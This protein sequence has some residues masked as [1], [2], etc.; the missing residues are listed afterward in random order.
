[1]TTPPPTDLLWVASRITKPQNLTPSAFCDWYENT[2]IQEVTALSGIP[3]AARYELLPGFDFPGALQHPWLT[4][5]EMREVGFRETEEF[6]GLD[7]Q[8]RPDEGLL[9]RVFGNV[10]FDTRFWRCVQVD[11]AAGARK[12]PAPLIISA[13][14]SPSP[15]AEA[16]FDAWYRQEHVPMISQC[17]GYV[18]TRRYRL[19]DASLLHEFDRRNSPAPSWLALHEFEGTELP[20]GELLKC[21][22]TEWSKKVIAG[23]VKME[24]GFYRLKR[25]YEEDVEAKL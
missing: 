23:L 17:P 18:R 22:E 20:M 1:M 6:R 9:E 24:A 10:E 12:G 25:I 8:S 4:L 11:E 14:L 3:S 21:D 15:S 16:D 19:V 7:G 13:A 5:Y 2:H